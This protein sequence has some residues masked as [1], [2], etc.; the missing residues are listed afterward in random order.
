MDVEGTKALGRGEMVGAGLDG[1]MK[2]RSV[3][4]D[5]W[6]R[7]SSTLDKIGFAFLFQTDLYET[8]NENIRFFGA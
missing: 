1:W 3:S 8:S 5:P 2:G 7:T 6:P 4:A